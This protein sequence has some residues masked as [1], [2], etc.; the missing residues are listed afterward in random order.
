MAAETV[1]VYT[2]DE[3]SDPLEGVLVRFFDDVDAYVTQNYSSLQGGESY[4]E[5]TLDGDD[6]PTAYTI[7][8]SKTGVAF[9]GSLGDDSKTPQAIE[10][11]SPEANAPTGKNYFTVQGQTFT[12]P[13]GTDPRLCRCSGYFVD[14]SGRPLADLDIHM[15]TVC[16]NE[17]QPYHSPLIVDGMAVMGDKVFSRT[18][19]TGYFQVDLYRGGEYAALVQGFEHSRRLIKVPDQPAISI[20]D[21]LFPVVTE[22]TFGTNPLVLNEG[23]YADVALT[24]LST[25]GQTL[26]ASDGDVTFDSSDDSVASIQVLEGNI[27][28]VMGVAI[29]SATVTAVRSDTSI[30]TIPEQPVTY[31][32]LSVTVS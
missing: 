28:R 19:S 3:N 16:H 24:I 11:Y 22:I 23:D 7:R 10:V 29:G 9:D 13:T 17:D 20:I 26:D 32:V 15:I 27:L 14:H 18:D 1:R 30:I 5:V 8:M 4:A 21:L 25:D 12:L 6:P 2:V 31:T